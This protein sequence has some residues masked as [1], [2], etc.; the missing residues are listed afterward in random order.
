MSSTMA[1]TAPPLTENDHIKELLTILAQS[2]K[3]AAAKEF[4]AVLSYVGAM[5]NQLNSAASE[6]QNIRQE[7]GAMRE[8]QNHPVRT[9]MQNAADAL[10]AKLSEARSH[11]EALKQ[12]IIEGAKNAVAAF[13]EHGISALDKLASFFHIKDGL[14]ALRGNLQAGI[15][16]DE[17]AIA[18]IESASAK[19]HEAGRRVKN[20][21]RALA[22]K[23]AVKD[24]KPSGKLA[25]TLEAPFRR[26]IACYTKA[27]KS[28]DAAIARLDRLAE[29]AKPSVCKAIKDS[30]KAAAEKGAE[31]SPE[32]TRTKTKK[33]EA[34]I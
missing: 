10:E 21:S 11:L 3:G 12:S 14:T 8:A 25:K 29:I 30:Q 4:L 17:R 20:A 33:Q 24:A 26:E 28:V 15:K 19:Y 22:G 7:L 31:K 34:E 32:K 5:E 23:E 2:R 18:T 16:E 6:L 9:A 13:K 1:A 27:V